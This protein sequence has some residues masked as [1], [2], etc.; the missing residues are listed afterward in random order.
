MATD[1]QL[2]A[3]QA[4]AQSKAQF[5]SRSRLPQRR[6]GLSRLT[7]H[8][9]SLAAGRRFVNSWRWLLGAGLSLLGV[10]WGV[11][12]GFLA[13]LV[14]AGLVWL[15]W[16][17]AWD[18]GWLLLLRGQK[19]HLCLGWFL[20]GLLLL[21]LPYLGLA[22]PLRCGLAGRWWVHRHF[23][24][25]DWVRQWQR[26]RRE[27]PLLL[28]KEAAGEAFWPRPGWLSV[29]LNY[30]LDALGWL[31]GTTTVA[32]ATLCWL[33][34][35][36]QFLFLLANASLVVA[37][38]LLIFTSGY[39]FAP[40]LILLFAFLSAAV[41]GQIVVKLVDKLF[42]GE[43]WLAALSAAVNEANAQQTAE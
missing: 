2:A 6:D 27:D 43:A 30:L 8:P 3:V 36:I 7:K 21:C 22:W 29:F 35:Y 13:L 23:A 33:L 20:L 34:A 38:G 19:W 24:R 4:V 5:A 16:R 25:R 12:S 31:C 9:V 37:M 26:R 18:A 40:I 10:A 39:A 11:L 32:V 15:C 14:L 42:M 17:Q 41:G 28:A 1:S